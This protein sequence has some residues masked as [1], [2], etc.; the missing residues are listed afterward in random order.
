M[1]QGE[2]PQLHTYLI[3]SREAQPTRVVV[4]DTARIRIGRHH[5]QDVVL[6]DPEVSRQHALL[7]RDGEQYVVEDLGTA[8]GT[9]VNE[10]PV[11]SFVLRPDD[12][13]RIGGCSFHF[14]RTDEDPAATL[15]HVVPASRLRGHSPPPEDAGGSTM[16][17]LPDDDDALWN[18]GTRPTGLPGAPPVVRNLDD[19][20]DKDEAS[21]FGDLDEPDP[22]MAS[23][24]DLGP[25]LPPVGQSVPAAPAAAEPGA[26]TA[27]SGADAGGATSGSSV[28]ITLQ[29]D[30][31][32][33]AL[34]AALQSLLGRRFDLR[35]LSVLLKGLSLR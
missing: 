33:P 23:A 26:I 28:E 4:W 32:D 21:D 6:D 9:F 25:P 30:G 13:I 19:E 18:V 27:P 20:V 10:E 14:C 7:R 17:G 34:L 16:L 31:V 2:R 22:L 1:A 3:V 12:V 15:S 11:R 35:A 8:N 5:E 24:F 29:L